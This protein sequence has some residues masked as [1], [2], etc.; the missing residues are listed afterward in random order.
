MAACRM[1]RSRYPFCRVC[2]HEMAKAIRGVAGSMAELKLG[3]TD[4]G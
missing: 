3:P 4:G 2:S 1:R